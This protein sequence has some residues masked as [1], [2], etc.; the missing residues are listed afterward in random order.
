MVYVL[1]NVNV[2]SWIVPSCRFI[3]P[4][5]RWRYVSRDAIVCL[6]P[7]PAQ[8]NHKVD[9]SEHTVEQWKE[10]IYKEVLAFDEKEKNGLGA[11]AA[12]AA[13]TAGANNVSNQ[14]AAAQGR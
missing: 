4:H 6:Q 3:E 2:V 7:P 9:E 11:A 13:A 10:L 8:Y 12:A 14:T 5:C 1:Q